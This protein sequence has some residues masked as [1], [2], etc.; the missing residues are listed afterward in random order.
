[1][2][3]TVLLTT[4]LLFA[5]TMAYARCPFCELKNAEKSENWAQEKTAK[6]TEKLG[7]TEEQA[8]QVEALVKEKTQK[9]IAVKEE[10]RTKMDSISEEYSAKIQALLTD[11]QKVKHEEWK[12][13]KE[14][15]KG[16]GYG[17]MHKKMH[18]GMYQEGM[19]VEED[20]GKK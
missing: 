18:K 5:A 16:E 12:K 14:E 2:K 10:A 17:Y 6:M 11:E 19:A 8:G 1:M 15:M 13:E 3:K 9:K 7:L 20:K 4:M